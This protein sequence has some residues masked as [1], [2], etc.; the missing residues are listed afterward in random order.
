VVYGFVDWKTHAKVSMVVRREAKGYRT[1]CHFGTGNYHPVTARIYT[2]VSYFTAE[3]R[4]GRDA[5]KLFNY[6]TG[7]LEPK[8]LRQ[9]V[10][11]PAGMRPELIRLIDVEIAAAKAGK[12]SGLWAKLNS[13][14]DQ[15]IIDK[16]YE[17]S[18]AGVPIDLVIR[19]IC[20]LRP[21]VPGLSD[22]IFV[23]SIVGRF[24]EHTR[25]WC[26]ANG[27][28][29]PHPS[30]RVYISSADWMPRNL[31]RRIEYM[32][33]IENPTVHAQLLEQVMVANLIDNE[34]SWRLLPDGTYERL[35]PKAND[36]FNLH[37]Y[38]MSNPSLSGRGQALKKGRKV[39]KL[40]FQRGR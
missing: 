17:A 24:L 16:L 37:E 22:K 11:S 19:G 5:A 27:H 18:Q 15:V 26:F 36:A 29:L 28:E 8:N 38:F 21:G 12:P 25:M 39:P 30:A 35:R 9:L 20:C 13:L 2:D 14:V 6:I 33:P 23:K 31:D 40:R 10:I 4:L 3:P 1:Y 7:Y 34:Q 32:L